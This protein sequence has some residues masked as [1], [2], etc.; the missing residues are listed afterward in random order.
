VFSGSKLLLKEGREGGMN[1]V[2]ECKRP[3]V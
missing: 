2:F 1:R 3:L